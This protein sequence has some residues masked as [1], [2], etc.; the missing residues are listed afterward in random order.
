M[1]DY[2]FIVEYRLENQVKKRRQDLRKQKLVQG[3]PRY[4]KHIIYKVQNL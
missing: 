4:Y 2:K 3:M 1:V